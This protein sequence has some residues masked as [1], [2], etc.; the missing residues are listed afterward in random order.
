MP[1]IAL[2]QALGAIKVLGP[3]P[4]PT[5][6]EFNGWYAPCICF[7]VLS[8]MLELEENGSVTSDVTLD[9]VAG[10]VGLHRASAL[11]VAGGPR[12]ANCHQ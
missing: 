2:E 12:S 5:G 8:F 10:D 11:D 9:A 7:E 6:E 4:G 3:D 1:T